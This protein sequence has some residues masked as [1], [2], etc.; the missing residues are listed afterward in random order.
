MKIK[1]GFR[2]R[3]AAS[4]L[5]VSVVV[6]STACG[7]TPDTG[8]SSEAEGKTSISVATYDGGIGTDWL[9]TAAKE[10]EARYA[11]TS[12]EDG[13][14]GV[15]ITVS[16]CE[17]GDMLKS[18]NLDK[19]LYLTEN[20]DYFTDY[21]N[22]GK[23]AD[24]TDAVTENLTEYGESQSI[25]DKL[26]ES[27]KSYLTAKDGK[28]YAIPFYDGIYGFIYN[29]DMFEANGW[30]FGED[31]NFISA[32]GTKSKGID[33]V[34]GNYDDGLPQT[35]SQFK[36][37]V[38][39]IRN[40]SEITPFLYG[41]DVKDK[42]PNRAVISFWSDYEGKEKMNVNYSVSG[43]TDVITSFNGDVPVIGTQTVDESNFND[44]QAQPGKYYALK[45]LEE[46]VCG[47]SGNYTEVGAGYSQAQFNF[48]A[49]DK[50]TDK[51]AILIDGIWWE[52]E[53]DIFGHFDNAGRVTG[54]TK[55][56][57]RYAFMPIPMTD[58]VAA[59]GGSHKQTLFSLNTS[60]CF[61]SGGTSGAKLEVSK[62]F[63]QFLHT[64][65]QL[66][67]F[68]ATTSV[69]RSLNYVISE[70]D[71]ETATYYG[72]SVIAMK[73][74]SDIVYPYSSSK[75]FINH[76]SDFSESNWVWKGLVGT[77]SVTSPFEEFT[78]GR[79]T[80]KDYFNGLKAAH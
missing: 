62:K 57:G 74:N 22:K 80:A 69:T 37:L 6:A 43:T 41:Q 1:N 33:G 78:N 39:R 50:A 36:K 49:G 45:F 10:F 9:K 54:I 29:V 3:I 60:Y 79:I 77:R 58:E 48:I 65:A 67:K 17:G 47:N 68:T 14:T 12:F 53:A 20:V 44:L 56:T 72:K 40:N 66:S 52:N 21:V 46:V 42:Y 27:M 24:I 26:D 5:L 35:Y 18:K 28:Y 11:D 64:D 63:L 2:K 30:Y 70:E 23:F 51:G 61:I 31:G 19:N 75:Y 59:S 34:P 25:A 15:S 55:A 16:K 71:E 73:K 13:K 76:S 32:G 38:E 4:A 7:G 8:K